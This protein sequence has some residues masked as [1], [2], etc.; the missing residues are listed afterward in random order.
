M[1]DIIVPKMQSKMETRDWDSFDI[2]KEI[3]TI[4]TR[5]LSRV[6]RYQPSSRY[7]RH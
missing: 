5:D 4:T 6:I 2:K 1:K 3:T 7:F